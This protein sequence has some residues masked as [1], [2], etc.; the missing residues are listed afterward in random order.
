M[1]QNEGFFSFFFSSL[2][3][4]SNKCAAF[5]TRNKYLPRKLNTKYEKEEQEEEEKNKKGTNFYTA[6]EEWS[7]LRQGLYWPS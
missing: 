5:G 4:L 1:K 6:A 2:F 3:F 7:A